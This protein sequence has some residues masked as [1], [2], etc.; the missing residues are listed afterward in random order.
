MPG[1]SPLK[2]GE[3]RLAFVRVEVLDRHLLTGRQ[4]PGPAKELLHRE[5]E[6]S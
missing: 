2:D 6:G 1:R 3:E 5:L 4:R